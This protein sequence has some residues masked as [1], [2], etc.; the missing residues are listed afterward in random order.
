MEQNNNVINYSMLIN[1]KDSANPEQNNN[2]FNQNDNELRR[3]FLEQNAKKDREL[4]TIISNM[5]EKMDQGRQSKISQP[6]SNSKVGDNNPFKMANN[7][8]F[9]NF[10]THLFGDNIG[11]DVDMNN[12]FLIQS[13]ENI[14]A[15]M[16]I[17]NGFFNNNNINSI[18]SSYNNNNVMDNNN[19][20]ININTSNN[21]LV[22]SNH[23]SKIMNDSN[24]FNNANLN[25]VNNPINIS[26]H[27]SMMN[28]GNNN[29]NNGIINNNLTNHNSKIF[30]NNNNDIQTI[31]MSN[32]FINQSNHNSLVIDNNQNNN[33]YNNNFNNN[34]MNNSI[35]SINNNMMNFNNNN[36]KN[37]MMDF[38]NNNNMMN[39]N[40][41]NNMMMNNFNMN[42]INNMM[43]N[44][45]INNSLN[46]KS[47]NISENQDDDNINND[48]NMNNNLLNDNNDMNDDNNDILNEMKN[49]NKNPIDNNNISNNI[50]SINIIRENKSKKN[51]KILD[52]N[53]SNTSNTSRKPIKPI[54]LDA[55]SN[56]NIFPTPI[57]KDQEKR[58]TLKKNEIIERHSQM[59]SFYDYTPGETEG[60]L[61]KLLEDINYYGEI[62]K[63]E[64]QK[65]KSENPNKFISIEDAEKM[66]KKTNL[67]MKNFKNEYFI[68]SILAKAL[69]SHGCLVVIE[70]DEPKTEEE[71]KEINTTLQFLV[72][73]MY[74]FKKYIFHFDFGNENNKIILKD[75]NK[76]GHFNRYLKQKL[77]QLFNLQVSDIIMTNPR[78]DYYFSITAI[79]KKAYFNELSEDNLYQELI[80]DETFNKIKEVE[81]SILLSGCKLNPHMLDSRGNNKDGGWGLNE[82]R[83][84]YPYF[85]PK[86]WSGYGLRVLD[87]YDYGDNT[88]LDY[89]NYEGEW[90]VAYHGIGYGLRGNELLFKI[91]N[92]G[93][94]NIKTG[95]KQEFK[96]LKD[97]FSNEG[98]NV[99]EGVYVT[100]Q[101]AL[102]DDYCGIFD[103][104]GKKYKIAFMTRVKPGKIRCPE[105][106][107]DYWVI[108]GTDNEIRPYRILIKE[109][110]N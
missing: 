46:E 107:D 91:N 34:I 16:N 41:N 29:F 42:N 22:K 35:N 56:N 79:I 103:Y 92:L 4:G 15:N 68:L 20:N 75:T 73:G 49:I 85:P 12:N 36:N 70:K 76:Q 52:N 14:N 39:F 65:Q 25:I 71:I 100:P 106:K 7:N 63:K 31:N 110:N 24:N 18:H 80:N 69:M 57:S 33:D 47:I 45:N 58:D 11:N 84:G 44:I 59:S 30:N 27:S 89:H 53:I 28:F 94:D 61:I 64:I 54:N 17:D 60:E 37:N 13:D 72:N 97:C 6:S 87:R 38:N 104:D 26:N 2:D 99:G 78:L 40:N 74:N 21:L 8:N 98:K 95:I 48:N 86:G 105:E 3:T 9:D 23:V 1:V 109:V 43:N 96:D 51:S 81:K 62:S 5:K 50:N 55:N 10:N 66:G 93:F 67:R 102:L 82:Q 101:P 90:A 19:N 83:G 108:N 88:W 32:N 77:M